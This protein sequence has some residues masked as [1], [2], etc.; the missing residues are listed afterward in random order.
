MS[1]EPVED[2]V[3]VG[4]GTAGWM[5]AASL[6]NLYGDQVQ[7]TL[8]ESSDIGTIG[9]GEA[10]NATIRRFYGQ[11]GMTDFDV[12]KATQGTCKLGIR[13]DDWHQKGHSYFHPFGVYGQ[14]VR[15]VPFHHFWLKMR[16]LGD[17]RPIDDYCLGTALAQ[18]G[19]FTLPSPNPPSSLS[20]FD[21]AL[22]FDATLFGRLMRDYAEKKGVKRVDAK[23]SG[24]NL[25][26]DNGFIESVSL[27]QGGQVHG[28]LF[29]DCSGFK[30]LLIEGALKTGYEDWSEWLLTD[31]A[32]AVQSELE[33]EPNPFTISTAHKAGWQWNIPLQ[34]RQGN[35][36]VFSSEYISDDEATRVLTDH[37][38][39]ELI[40]DPRVIR[41]VPGRRK[42]AWNK[43][44]IAVGLSS[45][46]L[47]PLE[48]TSIAL[49]ETAIE[50]IRMLFPD[51]GMDQGCIDEFNDMTRL[52]YERVRDFI[53][54][55]YHATA[56]DDSP[57]WNYCRNMSVPETLSHKMRLFRERGH[58]VKYRWEIFQPASWIALYTGNNILP[59][60][61]DPRVNTF[62]ERYVRDSLAQ[63]RQSLSTAV[64][65]LPSHGEF[66]RKTCD[67]RS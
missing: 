49:V 20:V 25:K 16:E 39:G 10:T 56:R 67:Y 4:G 22:H 15:R 35:G 33:G 9:V 28:D 21:W 52:E 1:S 6:S 19:K 64:A 11:L 3:I 55:H 54:L 34:H 44:C 18:A 48:S 12:L 31:R 50:K 66:I 51:K 46:F 32:V 40:G 59:K 7:I 36:H 17:E 60:R 14:E 2:I 65:P 26:P 13:F 58:L 43:N 37:I 8:V 57:M 29:I 24:V 45:G 5:T 30:G 41:F 53:I 63:M 23:I 27:E 47:E 61:Y 38:D 62:D 42:R